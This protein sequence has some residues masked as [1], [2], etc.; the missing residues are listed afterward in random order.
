MSRVGQPA[1]HIGRGREKTKFVRFLPDIHRGSRAPDA[2]QRVS[3]ALLVRG[4]LAGVRGEAWVPGLRSSA[5]AL[6]RARDTMAYFSRNLPDSM[7]F[8]SATGQL[9]TYVHASL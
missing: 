3:G 6:H 1:R 4:P 7:R 9:Y 2:A 5:G 8:N